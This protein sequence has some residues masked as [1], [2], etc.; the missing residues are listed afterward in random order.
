MKVCHFDCP[1]GAAGD[2][3]LGALLDVGVPLSVVE[4]ALGT[5]ALERWS[6]TVSET[7]KKGLRATRFT[8]QADEQPHQRS[9]A[10]I[11]SLLSASALAERVK[12]LAV[13]TF[14]TLGEAEAR[15][16]GVD[17]NAVLFHEVGA[18][19]ATIDIV[20]SCAAYA[21]LDPGHTTVS[22]LPLGSGTAATSHGE[23][24]VP[25]PAVTEILAGAGA[26]VV[27]GGEG[28]TVTPTGAALLVTFADAFGGPPPMRLGSTGYGAGSRD[29]DHMPNVLRL[30]VGE[31]DEGHEAPSVAPDAFVLETNIDDLSPELVAHAV[32]RL[33]AGG[34]SDAWTSPIT[35]K[36]GRSAV[37]LSALTTPEHRDRVLEVL[38]SETS[39]LGVRISPVAKE[40][41]E[42][43]FVTVEVRG[44]VV[45]VKLGLRRGKVVNRAPEYED[46]RA[47]AQALGL[48]L[49]E[50]YELVLEQARAP[51]PAR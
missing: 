39:T 16:H 7:T 35:M 45:R 50:V 31:L 14:R 24:P 46:A 30:L 18:L 34:A 43:D 12:T 11:E 37:T 27:A 42:R 25:V 38:F 10:D 32:E 5:L 1:A 41:L 40:E 20:G 36:K 48:P 8:V 33:L 22:P 13:S 21:H 4:Q 6:L 3:V 28:E 23:L 44:Q 9:F 47:A 19:D 51:R 26:P 29:T 49:R 17:L 15:V 2:M